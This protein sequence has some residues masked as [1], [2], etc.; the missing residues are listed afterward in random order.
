V[1]TWALTRR[2]ISESSGA[3]LGMH[4]EGLNARGCFLVRALPRGKHQR[5]NALAMKEFPFPIFVES[6][7]I[8]VSFRH[9]LRLA[10]S[11]TA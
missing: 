9:T 10:G 6:G 11:A 1:I 2:S 5:L 7:S 3:A 4:A 8:A